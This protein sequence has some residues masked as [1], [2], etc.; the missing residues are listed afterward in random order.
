VVLFGDSH[1]AQWLPAIEDLAF[2]R[3]WRVTALTKSACPPVDLSVW[4][5]TKKRS[6]RECDT[7]RQSA[8]DRIASEHPSIVFV[9]GY[10]VYEYMNGNE[11]VAIADDPAGW[12]QGLERTIS[13]IQATGAQV[14]L[15]ADTPQLGVI[16]DE[17]LA[18]HRDAIERC[19][20]QAADVV[21]ATYA[22]LE[23]QVATDT[24]ARLLS[25]TDVICPDGV[26]PLVFG[27]TPVYRDDQ[28]LTAT[29]ARSLSPVI[30]VWFDQEGG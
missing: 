23:Q 16:P 7:W 6:Y 13:A 24:S 22:Q 30:D 9:A 17:C 26:C 25:L 1:A 4:L 2:V 27:T 8:L 21:D 14:V 19:L 29:F 3:D 10:H 11:R 28:H 12:A 15:I 20:Q 18:D 5:A